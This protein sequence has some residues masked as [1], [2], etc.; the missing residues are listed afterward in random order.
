M[1]LLGKVGGVQARYDS[2]RDVECLRPRLLPLTTSAELDD[3]AGNQRS[4]AMTKTLCRAPGRANKGDSY[5]GLE[6]WDRSGW[7]GN[8]RQRNQ[9]KGHSL[10]LEGL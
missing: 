1:A 5:Q 7:R 10:R 2:V 4:P 3:R 8:D 6:V 9:G